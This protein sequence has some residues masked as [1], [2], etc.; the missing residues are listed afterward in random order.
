MVDNQC[1]ERTDVVAPSLILGKPGERIKTDRC[2]TKRFSVSNRVSLIQRL[3]GRQPTPVLGIG[4]K[5]R[6]QLSAPPLGR[7]LDHADR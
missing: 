3:P 1:G 4:Q 7:S 5:R 6:Q 2:D